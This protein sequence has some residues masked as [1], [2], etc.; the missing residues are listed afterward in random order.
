MLLVGPFGPFL[1]G[2]KPCLD[3]SSEPELTGTNCLVDSDD[4]K[5]LAVAR[6]QKQSQLITHNA[7]IKSSSSDAQLRAAR[8]RRCVDSRRPSTP[9]VPAVSFHLQWKFRLFALM[10]SMCKSGT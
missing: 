10:M 3:G 5:A 7:G 6:E 9:L 2:G 8:L 1:P 4:P